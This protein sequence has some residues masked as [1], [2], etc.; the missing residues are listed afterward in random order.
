MLFI[1]LH[2]STTEDWNVAVD[3][4]NAIRH[5]HDKPETSENGTWV[6]LTGDSTPI[7]V[8][9]TPEEI[10]ALLAQAIPLP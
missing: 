6:Y 8:M 3:K 9:E 5:N 1:K 2:Y 7:K 10:R 4:I